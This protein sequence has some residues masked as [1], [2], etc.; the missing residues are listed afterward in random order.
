MSKIR[1]WGYEQHMPVKFSALQK[2][3]NFKAF[4]A[5]DVIFEEGAPGD[6]MYVVQE[7]EVDIV[8]NGQV[9]ETVDEGNILG[10]LALIDNRPR[11]ATA[12]AKTDCKLAPVDQKQ[13][14]FM[15]RETP[16][17]AIRV[18]EVMSDRLRHMDFL[19]GK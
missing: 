11:S 6:V 15:L 12:L 7:G 10:E 19:S 16:Y 9:V 13:F 18:M 17:F 8:V 2:S 3:A 4:N 14:T 5:G 1:Q